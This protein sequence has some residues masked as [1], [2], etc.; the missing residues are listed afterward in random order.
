MDLAD[1]D[2]ASRQDDELVLSIDEALENLAVEDERLAALVK[3]RFF[4]GFTLTDAAEALGIARSTATEDLAYAK[5]RLR[6]LLAD[7]D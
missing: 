4:A 1:V 6:L 2:P 5:S 3:L 7:V